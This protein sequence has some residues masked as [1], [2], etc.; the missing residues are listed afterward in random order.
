ML[1]DNLFYMS[2]ILI[3]ISSTYSFFIKAKSRPPLD[4]IYH[5]LSPAIIFIMVSS[6]YIQFDFAI[7]FSMVIIFNIFLIIQLLQEIRDFDVDK[8]FIKTTVI[9][10][11]KR[12]SI[13]LSIVLLISLLFI[14]LA[15]VIISIFPIKSLIYLPLSYF[16][17]E[18]LYD[19]L[20]NKRREQLLLYYFRR[21]LIQLTI[22]FF[23]L[24]LV[25]NFI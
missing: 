25:L 18:P 20:N 21:R 16:L 1:P 6:F 23:I 11:G 4:L 3:L 15:G 19:S 17:F 9:V 24:F 22:I 10:I 5:G 7:L 8:K 12:N 2:L 13:K 14:V